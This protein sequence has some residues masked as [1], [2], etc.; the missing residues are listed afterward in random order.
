MSD[1]AQDWVVEP[2][3]AGESEWVIEPSSKGVTP[4]AEQGLSAHRPEKPIQN[5]N[6]VADYM[7]EWTGY[8]A[9]FAEAGTFGFGDELY[10][11]VKSTFSDQT[12]EEARDEAREAFSTLRKER[13]A[14][15]YTGVGLAAA[16]GG[17]AAGVSKLSTPAVVGLSA[18][19]GATAGAGFSEADTAAGMAQDVAIGGAVGAAAPAAFGAIRGAARAVGKGVKGMTTMARKGA[20]LAHHPA[21]RELFEMGYTAKAL[22]DMSDEAAEQELQKVAKIT[23]KLDPFKGGEEARTMARQAGD[24]IEGVFNRLDG[25]GVVFEKTRA[26][27][28]ARAF[29]NNHGKVDYNRAKSHINELVKLS[30]DGGLSLKDLQKVRSAVLGE[31]RTTKNTNDKRVLG[32]LREAIDTHLDD[33][34]EIAGGPEEVRTF[35]DALTSYD[36]AQTAKAASVKNAQNMMRTA[37]R[38]EFMR[39]QASGYGAVKNLGAKAAEKAGGLTFWVSEKMEKFSAKHPE[40]IEKLVQ[41]W[42]DGGNPALNAAVNRE[43][44][45]NPA[46]RR[47]FNKSRNK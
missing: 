24:Q 41:A 47:D 28:L 20:V 27:S 4:Q 23:A 7:P 5:E 18:A 9:G 43:I 36:V 35:R 39:N 8:A 19:E 11:A 16:P 3:P 31:I 12:Y 17:V 15:Y 44:Q 34:V 42:Y 30:E 29:Q 45:I 6:T 1:D 25:Q 21:K 14:Q 10:G 26:R 2:E 46:F 22:V 40:A 38:G 33:L 32:N 37:S 13:P